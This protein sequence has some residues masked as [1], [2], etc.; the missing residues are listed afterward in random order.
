MREQ[1]DEIADKPGGLDS[2]LVPLR[3]AAAVAYSHV[4]DTTREVSGEGALAEIVHIVA[5]A[6]STV[7]PIHRAGGGA[8]TDRELREL[9]Y[10]PLGN[11]GSK[12]DLDTLAIRRGD[13]RRAM[14]TLK[15]ARVVFAK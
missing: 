7:A 8:L 5:I 15:E 13:L 1:K 2:E 9:L 6:L 11:A 3:V 14:V 10:R 12:P 4:T